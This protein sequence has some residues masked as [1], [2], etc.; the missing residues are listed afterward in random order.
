MDSLGGA[1]CLMTA[2]RQQS[3]LD[4]ALDPV[5]RSIDDGSTFACADEFCL[6]DLVHDTL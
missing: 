1:R 4:N 5:Q 3:S 2:L 6:I